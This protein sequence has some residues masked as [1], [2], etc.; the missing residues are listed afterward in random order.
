MWHFV[1]L[2]VLVPAA[3]QVAD[4]SKTPVVAEQASSIV[5][6]TS[7]RPH[8]ETAKRR[9]ALERRHL[10]Q[11]YEQVAGQLDLAGQSD[12]DAEHGR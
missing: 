1:S 7:R 9:N 5:I 8:D 12:T 11:Q 6:V 10:P 4:R 2:T 3:A